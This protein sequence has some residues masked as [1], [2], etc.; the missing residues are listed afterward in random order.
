MQEYE[1]DNAC[2]RCF[3]QAC[4]EVRQRSMLVITP[5]WSDFR[6]D[7]GVHLLAETC[8]QGLHEVLEDVVQTVYEMAARAPMQRT[9]S[10][11]D[12]DTLC[13]CWSPAGLQKKSMRQAKD[14]SMSRTACSTCVF[15]TG[16]E[17]LKP[18]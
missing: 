8:S 6:K 17:T 3:Q 16:Q 11:S 14:L 18:Y 2:A 15:Q 7:D 12:R 1:S 4:D 9:P 13:P 10:F 5:P